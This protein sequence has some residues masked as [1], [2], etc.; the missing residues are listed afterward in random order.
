[1]PKATPGGGQSERSDLWIRPIGRPV[2]LAASRA[3]IPLRYFDAPPHVRVTVRGTRDPAPSIPRATSNETIAVPPEVCSR[4]GRRSH[5]DRD[6]RSSSC[7]ASCGDQRHLGSWCTASVSSKDPRGWERLLAARGASS[8]SVVTDPR[9]F[10][11]RTSHTRA[12]A[13][14]LRER[15]IARVVD[16]RRDRRGA[17]RRSSR[18]CPRS[19]SE[20]RPRPG[21]RCRWR[22]VRI[23]SRRRRSVAG[24]DRSGARRSRAGAASA[25]RV[26][27]PEELFAAPR[28]RSDLVVCYRMLAAAAAPQ[29]IALARRLIAAVGD[30]GVGVYFG[31]VQ[32][33][34]TPP[35]VRASLLDAGA[36][37]RD[38]RRCEP[39]ARQAR[40]RAVH[41][42]ERLRDRRDAGGVRGRGTESR[43]CIAIERHADVDY[44][45]AF[46]RNAGLRSARARRARLN[47]G[48]AGR[49]RRGCVRRRDPRRG[50]RP[51]KTISRRSRHGITIW[52]SRSARRKRRRRCSRASAVLLQ[53]LRHRARDDGS[54]VRRRLRAGCRGYSRRWAAASSWRR[55]PHRPRIARELYA[56]SR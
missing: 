34:G 17:Q 23:P 14:V 16:A 38:E 54:R 21:W 37:A 46:A 18:R 40:R 9:A 33:R 44:A 20:M 45:I 2:T 42:D 36:R 29:A 4:V 49:C 31:V 13:A 41:S 8:F 39:A 22:G 28:T 51:P 32:P 5:H 25:H 1:M 26:Q 55:F 52:R 7:R 47:R 50:T 15:R 48:K 35:T 12:R 3:R 10:C 11:A 30:D 6:V 43:A 56:A 27:G 19:N 24:D 53:A